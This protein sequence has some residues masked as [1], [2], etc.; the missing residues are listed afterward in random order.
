MH[1]S[2]SGVK[3]N[4]ACSNLNPGCNVFGLFIEW[5]TFSIDFYEKTKPFYDQSGKN[6]V[7]LRH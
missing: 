5:H 7:V 6:G 2:M 1:I 3:W 4:S